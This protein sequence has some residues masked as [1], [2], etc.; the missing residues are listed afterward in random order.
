MATEAQINANQQNAQHSTGPKTDAGKQTA[1]ANAPIT[2]G[3]YC[4]HDYIRPEEGQDYLD[5]VN[6]YHQELATEG[7]IEYTLANEIIG[8]AWRLRRCRYVELAAEFKSEEQAEKL[9]KSIERAR[10]SAHN[11]FRRSM[12]EL[13]R[14]QSER[15][16]REAIY[17]DQ[18]HIDELGVASAK[19]IEGA[20]LKLVKPEKLAS[21][22]KTETAPAAPLKF[23]ANTPRGARC[24]CKS[25]LK[26]K[27]C[28]GRKASS[29]QEKAA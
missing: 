24:P 22:C 28:C 21:P 11:I 23:P 15:H 5:F 26:Y 18:Q 27:H 17:P 8:A 6:Q 12:A 4:I 25:G 10:A 13:R 16:L 29:A 1:A 7:I 9:A 2:T 14:L 19:D 20:V 3:M